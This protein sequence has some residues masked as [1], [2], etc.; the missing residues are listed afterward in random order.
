MGNSGE[1]FIGVGAYNFNST[2]FAALP[3]VV[4]IDQNSKNIVK[5]YEPILPSDNQGAAQLYD[6]A[7]VQKHCV[8]VGTYLAP[9]STPPGNVPYPLVIISDDGGL[10]F[11]EIGEVSITNKVD[12]SDISKGMY[13]RSI[14]CTEMNCIAVGNYYEI[15]MTGSQPLVLLS[16]DGG[17]SFHMN[18][19]ILMPEDT[20]N[21]FNSKLN[22]V[23][24]DGLF[25]TAVGFYN[26][27]S[28]GFISE[29]QALS[30]FS[31]DGGK[32][33]IYAPTVPFPSDGDRDLFS[34][35]T[36]ASCI[37]GNCVGVGVY[38][39]D[40]TTFETSLLAVFGLKDEMKFTSAT[41]PALPENGNPDAFNSLGDII[42]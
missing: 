5:T 35:L 11:T 33:F 14:T 17:L 12:T 22:A 3:L 29:L 15:G 26:H 37:N 40:I 9:D 28:T 34:N 42:P 32:N 27:D 18:Y 13:L 1:N 16:D 7:C 23:S 38:N 2:T 36:G 4:V 25:C 31:N 10:T 6:V 39:V 30:L 20:N 21:A 24:C 41:Q 8:A 19:S